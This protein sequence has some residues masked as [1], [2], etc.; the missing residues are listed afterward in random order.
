M[1]MSEFGKVA[2]AIKRVGLL[3]NIGASS[4]Y[5]SGEGSVNIFAKN[6]NRFRQAQMMFF[7]TGEEINR[8]GAFE[9]ARREF[10]AK[11]PGLNWESNTAL[12]SIV[13]RADDLSMNMAQT[14]EA[15]FSKGILGIPL[16]FLQHNI[17]LGTNIFA[18][19]SGLIGKKSP[20]LTTKEAF[21]L[22]IGSYLLYGINNNATPD[23]IEDWL[24]NKLNSILSEQQKQYLTQGLLA[25]IISTIGEEITGQRTNIALGTRLSSLQWYEDL[26]DAVY[27]LFKGDK[28]DIA[29]LAGPTGSTL[30]S[31]LEI[32]AIFTDYIN[33]DEFS[34]ADFGRTLSTLG[35]TM[36]S[37]WRGIDKAYW[38]Y[39]ANGMVLNKRGDPQ[40]I[41][42][43]PEMIFQALG[44]Q[45]TEAYESSTVFKTNQDYNNTMQRYADTVMRLE[46]LA[47]KAYLAGDIE[48][49][50]ANN[51]AASAVT[52]PLPQADQ[53]KIKRM[54]KD[55]TSYDTVGR[56]AFN[57][58][59]TQMSSH[60]NRLLVTN[61]YG[62]VNGE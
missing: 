15:R 34:L 37:S 22:T 7:N 54:V 25:G 43:T 18:A 52:A 23:F 14:N 20:T 35:A 19:M 42:T 16:Q 11:N 8:V 13:Q 48:S 4:V 46:G 12:E 31:I 29:K 53:I 36:V 39:H 32:P 62:E 38:A 3:D 21:Q 27:G 30:K 1:D 61:P 41:L 45:S 5:N 17:R 33:K 59:A 58:W 44:F 10:I 6:Q 24:G 51:R 28:V 2:S 55:S 40:A 56:E 49:M 47:R 60:K 26:G 50:N 57:K 9:I